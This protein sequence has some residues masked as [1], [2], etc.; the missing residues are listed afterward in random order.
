MSI[1]ALR[2]N[3]LASS[4]YKNLSK[5]QFNLQTTLE[6]LSSGLR[7][8]KAADDSAGSAISTRM[9]N[10]IQGMKQANENSQQANNLIQTAENGLNDISGMLSR[11]REL[12]VQA[13]TDTL[14]D[15]DRASINLEYQALKNEITRVANVTEYN[16]MDILNG[17]YYRNQVDADSSTADDVSGVSIQT[18]D[19]VIKGAYSLQDSLA[20]NPNG[21]LLD[22][23]VIHTAGNSNIS[24]SADKDVATG[25]YRLSLKSHGYIKL[26]KTSDGGTTW[27]SASSDTI[28]ADSVTRDNRTFTFQT[29]NGKDVTVT[30][31]DSD[32]DGV[33]DFKDGYPK[34]ASK[35]KDLPAAFS[36]LSGNLKLWLDS[37]EWSAIET[38][39]T[40]NSNWIDFS[41]KANHIGQSATS[42]TLSEATMIVVTKA[43][44]LTPTDSNAGGIQL[45]DS[46]V[47]DEV[48][49]FDRVLTDTEKTSINDYLTNKWGLDGGSGSGSGSG[50][51]SEIFSYT[52]SAQTF[53]SPSGVTSIQIEAWGAQGGNGNGGLGGYA[54][55]NLT[56]TSG[57]VLEVNVGGA[58]ASSGTGGYNGGGMAGDQYGAAGGGA[59]DVRDG[60]YALVDRVIVAGGGGGG[61]SLSGGDGGGLMGES[62]SS[63]GSG[64]TA[65]GGG[66]QVAGGPAG[67][68][69]QTT[70]DGGLGYGGGTGDY[71]NAG[72]GG[73]WY[74]GGS[75]AGHAGAGGGSSYIGEVSDGSTQSG[76]R[77]GNGLVEISYDG[78][79][80]GTY[81]NTVD[82]AP[83]K[84]LSNFTVSSNRTLSLTSADGNSQSLDYVLG[85]QETLAFSNFG[86]QVDLSS[87]Y[88][89]SNGLDGKGVEIAAN[90]DLQ[91]G[92]DN[93]INHQLQLGIS[94]VTASGLRIDGS[95]VVDID[96]AR[97][98]ITSLDHAT[99]MVNQE[100]SYLG[101]MQN[102]LSFTMSNLTSNIQSIESSRS[103]I[104]DVD[105]AAEAAD[106]AKNQ[107]LAQSG[108]AMLAQ[109]AAISQNILGLLA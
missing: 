66:T 21:D 28:S 38:D 7:I 8:N 88:D 76:V 87:A 74:G 72:G 29:T 40:N 16:E 75:G 20:T 53:I 35:V 51:S 23:N 14:N 47:Y 108:T 18:L 79:S 78:T 11:M 103:S 57:Q 106:L 90:R 100:R 25:D 24:I 70:Q 104:E 61:S 32:S 85:N 36:G 12:A 39:G 58:G 60:A 83:D 95:Q 2:S 46:S 5:S 99:D 3:S 105:F 94:S 97:A 84:V 9:N 50:A 15:T 102:R 4:A 34:N 77:S 96:Q 37:R 42:E 82:S 44:A 62:G 45:S 71:H 69:F 52:G 48:L 6:R 19:K 1:F 81:S 59:S 92:A 93:D 91:V 63:G 43:G 13:A 68:T 30:F 80:P 27:T 89:P 98:A 56:M 49:V 107:I 54:V 31:P 26:E 22:T 73:G 10:Q 33:V 64:F 17:T 67:Y 86:I 109:A 101:S 55:G 41:G 65:G